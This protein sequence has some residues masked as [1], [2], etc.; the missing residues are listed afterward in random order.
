[1]VLKKTGNYNKLRKRDWFSVDTEPLIIY[2]FPEIG[3]E[4]IWGCIKAV[5]ETKKGILP[6]ELEIC[7][8]QCA[9][10]PSFESGGGGGGAA[11]TTSLAMRRVLHLWEETPVILSQKIWSYRRFEGD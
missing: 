6:F 8:E 10:S 4:S 7:C 2:L 9:R 5:S 11:E 3:T 1:M